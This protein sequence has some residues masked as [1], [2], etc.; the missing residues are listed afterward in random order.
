VANS[1]RKGRAVGYEGPTALLLAI[2]RNVGADAL[3]AGAMLVRRH[4]HPA[5][6]ANHAGLTNQPMPIGDAARIG[7]EG[8]AAGSSDLPAAL[9]SELS[10]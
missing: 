1:W 6:C 7:D 10:N 5:C 8:K 4:R 3:V 2:S 9:L